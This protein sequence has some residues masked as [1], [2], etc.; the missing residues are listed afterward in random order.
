[1]TANNPIA[2]RSAPNDATNPPR[3][4]LIASDIIGPNM[5]GSGIRYWNLARVIGAQQPVTLA[6]ST[7]VTLAAPP[8]VT[9]RS[10]GGPDND[11]RGHR[12]AE[13]IAAHDVVVAQHIPYLF[14]DPEILRQ[15]FMIVD[16]YAPWILEKLEHARIDAEV[17]EPNR[18]DDVA[19]LNR[20]LSLGDAFMA[21]SE[22]QR[23]FWLGALASAGRLETSHA[24]SDPG[25]RNLI[26]VVPFGLPAEPPQ[27][28]GPGP[29]ELFAAI[30]RDALLI[31]WNGGL[32]NWLDPF[33]AIRAMALV[34][35]REPR[36]RLVFMGVRSPSTEIARMRVVDDTRE[37]AKSLG[38]I[39]QIVFFN[40]WVAYDERQNWLL[41]ADLALSLHQS[42]LESRFAYRTRMLDNLWCRLPLVATTGDVLADLIDREEIGITVPPDDPAAVA[43]AIVAALDSSRQV[44]YRENLA[45]IAA[46]HSW[47]VV[48][49]PLLRWCERP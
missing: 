40:D 46:N 35:K 27:R 13:L 16:L 29:R 44:V 11:S 7:E 43:D 47:E 34:A 45:R 17:G 41:E 48:S 4:L 2:P 36:A 22:R 1:M 5:A 26:D 24:R 32:W 25:L 19:I 31:L 8:A 10:Y 3:V 37:L 20:L 12:L 33:T 38:L 30:G 9:L 14:T 21:A 23:D 15:R 49:Q 6:T 39:D 18:K 28:S 42:S